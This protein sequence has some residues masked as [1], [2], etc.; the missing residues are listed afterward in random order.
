MYSSTI[1]ALEELYP[2]L[3]SGGYII[4]DDFNLEPCAEAVKDYRNANGITL[5][6]TDVDGSGA[7]WCKE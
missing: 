4:I 1:V 5:P 7:Y 3:S 2:K 6:I